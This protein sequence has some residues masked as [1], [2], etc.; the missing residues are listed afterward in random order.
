MSPYDMFNDDRESLAGGRVEG[1]LLGIVTSNQDDKK[2]GRV[3]VKFPWFTEE[4]YWARV[5]TLMAGKDR[6]TFF[7]P[8]VGDE[9]LVA[10]DHGDMNYPYVIGALWNGEDKPPETNDDGKN[11]LR[12]IKSRLGHE[13]IFND[14]E[15][16]G[17]IEIQTKAG[18]KIILDDSDG[19]EKVEIKDKSGDN[20]VL[21][22]SAQNSIVVSSKKI[23]IKSGSNSI[24]IDSAQNSIAISSQMKLNIKAQTIEIEAGGMMTLKSSGTLTIQGSLVK[25]N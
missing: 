9:V 13:L 22:D 19:K 1:V 8:E 2:L 15:N 11:N 25:I 24:L 7:L 18:H 14:E 23:E 4:S 16:K 3:K 21:M 10:F 6:G 17:K 20:S 12:K 5:A